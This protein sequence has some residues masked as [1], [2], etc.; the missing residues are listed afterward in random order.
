MFD[1]EPNPYTLDP[2]PT[3]VDTGLGYRIDLRTGRMIWPTPQPPQR[4]QPDN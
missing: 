1:D 4:E 2:G 3:L